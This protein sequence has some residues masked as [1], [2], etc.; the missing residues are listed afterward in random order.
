MLSYVAVIP[1]GVRW[2]L[3]ATL[4]SNFGFE[5]IATARCEQIYAPILRPRYSVWLAPHQL[6]RLL[7]SNREFEHTEACMPYHKG[8]R[9][10]EL[11]LNLLNYN[12]P[13]WWHSHADI[14]RVEFSS[15]S[16]NLTPRSQWTSRFQTML[17]KGCLSFLRIAGNT[18]EQLKYFYSYFR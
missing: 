16:L 10:T 3:C 15:Q 2:N 5:V 7:F 1:S 8:K 9:S 18:L 4:H 12:R 17:I 11:R 6:V 14:V 13:V